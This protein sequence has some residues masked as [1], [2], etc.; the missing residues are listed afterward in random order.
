MTAARAGIELNDLGRVF[1]TRWR[2][3]A[4]QAL[5]DVTFEVGPGEIVGLLGPNGA[6]KT[7][8][9]RILSTLLL[10][11]AGSA[12]VAGADVV[13]SPRHVQRHCGVCFGGD[14]GL[15]PRLSGRDNLRYF[16]TMYG[17]HGRA[18]DARIGALL[19][20]VGLADR[21][22]DRVEVFSRGMRQRLHLARALLHDPPVLILDEPSAGLDPESARSL[23][24][25]VRRL[26]AEGRSILLTTHDLAEAE[27]L[28][29]RVVILREGR[30]LTQAAPPALREQAAALT[31]VRVELTGHQL[32][33][34]AL[35]R[36]P[37]V[38]RVTT[39]GDRALVYTRQPAAAVAAVLNQ[40][41]GDA[42][43]LVISKPSLE[44]AYLSLLG[45][46]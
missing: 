34:A 9:A 43:S 35:S 13:A 24:A 28:C 5:A 14:L 22:D 1:R 26:A 33:A 40:A 39:D 18:A 29:Q 38:I 7:T 16:A 3:P 27:A 46:A 30:V 8:C 20:R 41:N 36:L 12:R 15:Y 2:G 21:A 10:P 19:E 25:M 11:S 45:D 23:R 31:G 32:S 17:I 6:G 44:N 42:P 4:R 37:G